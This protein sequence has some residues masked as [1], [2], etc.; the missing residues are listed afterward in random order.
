MCQELVF[1]LTAARRR[2]V[3]HHKLNQPTD[4][5]STHSRPKAAG[6]IHVFAVCPDRV[7]THSRPKAAG[8]PLHPQ[9]LQPL[10]FNSQ[11]PEGGWLRWP[12]APLKLLRFQLTAARRRLGHDNDGRGVAKMFQLTAAR[13]R[14]AIQ[15]PRRRKKA[16]VSTHSRPKAAGGQG[17]ARCAAALVSTHSRPKAAGFSTA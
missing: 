6:L 5:V 3:I 9:P 1:Q 17:P 2:L 13:R 11:P 14:L 8:A 10:R 12:P 7:S 4:V 15:P 16:H